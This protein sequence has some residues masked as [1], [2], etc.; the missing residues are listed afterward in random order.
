MFRMTFLVTNDCSTG[1]VLGCSMRSFGDSTVSI[2]DAGEVGM[3]G[4]LALDGF[5]VDATFAEI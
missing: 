1:P 5:W 2:D 3:A 4:G